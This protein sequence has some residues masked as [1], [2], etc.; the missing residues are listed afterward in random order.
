MLADLEQPGA[1]QAYDADLCIIG[2]GAAGITLA[3]EFAGSGH[4]VIVLEAGGLTF[5]PATQNSYA[6]TILERWF[7]LEGS[8]LRYFGGT[9][10]HWEGWCGP[11]RPFDFLKRDWVPESGWPIGYDDLRPYYKK[12]CG[13]LQLGEF[14]YE[15]VAATVKAPARSQTP[16]GV[17]FFEGFNIRP[18]PVPRLGQTQREMLERAENV[19][20]LMHANVQPMSAEGRRL[21]EVTVKT[22]EGRTAQVR[23]RH[24]VL[25]CGGLENARLL[26]A[27]GGLA[28]SSGCVGRYFKEHT[29]STFA[30]VMVPPPELEERQAYLDKLAIPAFTGLAVSTAAQEEMK[31]LG[32]SIGVSLTPIPDSLRP[33]GPRGP[34]VAFPILIHGENTSDANSRVT[35]S[36]TEKDRFGIPRI[37]LRWIVDE[38]TQRAVRETVLRYGAM[39]NRAGLGRCYVPP[40]KSEVDWPFGLYAP[41]HPAGTTRMSSDPRTGVVDGDCRSH[42]IE[43]LYI[44]GGSTFPTNGFMN[45][46][47]TIVAMAFRLADHLKSVMKG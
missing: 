27:S 19:R 35:L 46:T 25:A 24:F 45:P 6:G 7:N 1:E 38:Q 42:D 9:T 14:D 40:E 28:N 16:G 20:I 47:M 36:A 30:G 26:L 29:F 15:A 33:P 34:K 8:R 21:G 4:S 5:D 41:C 23:A 11:L 43:N 18:T 10:N 32:C 31:L 13:Y 12:A 44:V 37:E 39:L 3:R 17:D 22:N 2:S